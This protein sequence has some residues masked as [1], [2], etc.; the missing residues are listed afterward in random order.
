MLISS[1][2]KS[3]G[4]G[5]LCAAFATPVLS[6]NVLRWSYQADAPSLDPH[7]SGNAF[8]VSLLGNVYE[9]LVSLDSDMKLAPGLAV[10]WETV[11]PTRWRFKLREGVTFHNGNP[12]TAEDVVFTMRRL[13]DELSIFRGRIS[14]VVS[15]EAVDSHTI[16]MVTAQPNPIL[17]NLI[18]SL[19]MM[20]KEWPEESL[21]P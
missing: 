12:F 10:S 7:G 14:S 13:Q 15:V 3:L 9:P 2:I 5:L 19:F 16:D 17:P 1:W 6:E 18:T 11:E 8:V 21:C 4:I 20:D